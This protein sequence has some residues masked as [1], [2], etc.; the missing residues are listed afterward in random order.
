MPCRL[1]LTGFL[2]ENLKSET[3][4]EIVQKA[5]LT[6][7]EAPLLHPKARQSWIISVEQMQNNGYAFSLK[8]RYF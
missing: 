2:P 5:L 8:I 4:I 1:W 6:V 3:G 7:L